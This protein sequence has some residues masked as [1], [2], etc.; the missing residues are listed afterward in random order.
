MSKKKAV[1]SVSSGKIK[2]LPKT[3]PADPYS[4][5]IHAG[6]G[7]RIRLLQ[8]LA[9]E[10]NLGRAGQM[11]ETALRQGHT[12]FLFGN[13]GSATQASHF[14]AELVNRFRFPRRG[15]PALSL[16]ADPANLTSIANDDDFRKVFSK[17]LEALGRARDVA[18]G[19]TTSGSSANILEALR[20]ARKQRLRTVAFCGENDSLLRRIPV[21]VIV[22]VD[23]DDTPVIQE[24]HQ[25]LL[26]VLA[27]IIEQRLRGGPHA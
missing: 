12:V 27:E 10:T 6:I 2:S 19:I 14:A 1:S 21:E 3:S 20:Q 16:T 23:S 24:L 5:A 8:G 25:F 11:L 26:H 22:R 9:T 13:G 18:V 7:S 15:L 4:T 17:Q